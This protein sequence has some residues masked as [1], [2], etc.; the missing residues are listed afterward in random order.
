MPLRAINTA[1][2][3]SGTSRVVTVPITAEEGD[4][5]TLIVCRTNSTIT[6]DLSISGWTLHGSSA[7][8]VT[9]GQITIWTKFIT[10]PDIG[11]TVTVEVASTTRWAMAVMARHGVIGMDVAPVFST[12]SDLTATPT[13]PSITTV[14]SNTELVSIYGSQ[15]YASGTP[16]SFTIPVGQTEI[17]DISSTNGSSVNAAFAIGEEILGPIG[18]SGTRQAISE[19]ADTLIDDRVR[20]GTATLAFAVASGLTPV[21]EVSVRQSGAWVTKPIKTRNGGTWV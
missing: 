10:A 21:T 11:A 8:T 20:Q 4:L 15:P 12:L 14:S 6:S 17:A 19:T 9:G 7:A 2:Y 16:I 1:I 5:A 13:A 3:S 18:V